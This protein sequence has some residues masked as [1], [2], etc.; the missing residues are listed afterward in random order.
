[1]VQGQEQIRR[2]L[3]D[4]EYGNKLAWY[5]ANQQLIEQTKE[6]AVEGKREQT[7]EAAEQA[8]KQQQE[9]TKTK[10]PEIEREHSRGFGIGM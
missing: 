9:Q 8:L 4:K 2:N 3:M 5:Q 6:I 10:E 7:G 1:M